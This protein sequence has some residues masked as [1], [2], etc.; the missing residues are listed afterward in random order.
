MKEI[1]F[2]V[3]YNDRFVGTFTHRYCPAFPVKVEELENIVITKR[4][5]LRGKRFHIY[6]L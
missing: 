3:M 6:I 1:K 4:P 5:T 2:D